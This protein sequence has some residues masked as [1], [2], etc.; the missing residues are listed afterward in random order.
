MTTG[1]DIKAFRKWFADRDWF[2]ENDAYDELLDTYISLLAR[3]VPGE[4]ALEIMNGII[5]VIRNEYGE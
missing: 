4:T 5:A 3:G 1:N 2:H